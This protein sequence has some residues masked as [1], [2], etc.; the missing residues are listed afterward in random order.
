MKFENLKI[1]AW[2]QTPV[3]CDRDAFLPI[4]GIL[5]QAHVR[6]IIGEPQL[7]SRPNASIVPEALDRENP[8]PIK[9]VGVRQN[10][11]DGHIWHYAA[12]FAQ[13]RDR[14]AQSAGF[15]TKRFDAAE[16]GLVDFGKRL[17]KVNTA[18]GAYKGCQMPVFTRHSRFVEWFV[19]GDKKRIRRLLRFCTAIGKKTSQGYGA[20]LKW[21][22][23]N[24]RWDWS[25]YDCRGRL[26][27]A[28]P[29]EKGTLYGIRPSYWNPKH[30]FPCRLPEPADAIF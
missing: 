30:Q 10:W 26:M 6:E 20:V 5:Y 24:W 14:I 11:Y 22:V 7:V 16:S 2:L 9:K 23:H 12:S 1:T 17:A 21:E 4:D 3:V 15:W 25:I 27:R 8:L 18:K 29:A 28:V 19:V 13:W